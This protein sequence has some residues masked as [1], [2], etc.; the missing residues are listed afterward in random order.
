VTC[1]TDVHG[2]LTALML[3]AA[4]GW[5]APPFFADLTVRHPTNDN[6]E[7]L[8]HCGNFPHALAAG[9]G[10]GF[11]GTH[12]VIPPHRPG[13]GNFQIRG[14]EVT[15]ARFDGIGGQYSLL[16]G[17]GQGTAG[18]FTLGTYLWVEVPDWPLW[19]ER[20]I[21]GP[22]IHHVAGIHGRW[23]PALYEATRY[24]PGLRPDPVQPSEAEIQAYLRSSHA[25]S[26]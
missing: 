3:Q 18:P 25:Q 6:A 11:L 15:I 20:V 24:L 13:T 26:E 14:G 23:A 1:E 22:Y 10:D 8:W 9:T 5:A 21:R 17:H 7:L 4:C 12:F 16:M 19:E 2:A